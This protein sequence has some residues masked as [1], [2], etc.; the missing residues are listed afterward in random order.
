MTTQPQTCVGGLLYSRQERF[1]SFREFDWFSQQREI[2][3]ASSYLSRVMSPSQVSS[4]DFPR[5][6]GARNFDVWKE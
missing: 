3:P 6:A 4:D 1:Q 2:R 5:L